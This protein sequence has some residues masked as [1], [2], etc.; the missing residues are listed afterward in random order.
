MKIMYTYVCDSCNRSEQRAG[1][2]PPTRCSGCGASNFS[3]TIDFTEAVSPP[4]EEFDAT[5]RDSAGNIRAER[6]SRTD[7]NTSSELESDAGRPARVSSK[8]SD[9]IE[10]FE[11]EA[12]AAE[13]L[14]KEFNAKHKSI[15]RVK[16]KKKEDSDY[17]DRI[18]E[19]SYDDP[20]TID[21]QV[22]HFD[23]QMVAKINK[24]KEFNEQRTTE[25]FHTLISDSITAKAMIDPALK[26]RAILLL[27]IPATL[28]VRIRTLI[29]RDTFDVKGFKE[30]WVSPFREEPFE[31]FP[32]S[33]TRLI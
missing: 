32:A 1:T 12:I 29:Q 28:G 26:A 27:Q 9:R 30:V 2:N 13:A 10:G 24:F 11:E 25:E 4:L 22:R 31:I 6:I 8:R 16:E 7:G 21:I 19:S 33:A 14:V 18:F 5:G 15:Y 20:A 17:A 3:V 23:T